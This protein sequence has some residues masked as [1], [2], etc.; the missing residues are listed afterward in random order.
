MYKIN[1][2]DKAFS[3]P[4]RPK[5]PTPTFG[6]AFNMGTSPTI[7]ET[8][9]NPLSFPEINES[10]NSQFVEEGNKYDTL[11]RDGPEF[12]KVSKKR[13]LAAI[14]A[15]GLAG[16]ANPELGMQVGEMIGGAPKR[17][18]EE[19]Y[20]RKLKN[21]ELLAKNEKSKLAD[22]LNLEGI[23]E[24]TRRFNIEDGRKSAEEKRRDA[25]L[26]NTTRATDASVA[27][28][29]V[30]TEAGKQDI[31]LRKWG[32]YT[33]P[34]DGNQYRYRLDNPDD[35]Q[36]I[37]KVAITPGE[38]LD[39]FKRRANHDAAN[40]LRNSLAVVNRQGELDKESDLRDF[41]KATTVADTAANS[42]IT[43]AR[44]KALNRSKELKVSEQELAKQAAVFEAI[45][46]AK[47]APGD[48]VEYDMATGAMTV[49]QPSWYS[50]D[51]DEATK[52]LKETVFNIL[53]GKAGGT[54][55]SAASASAIDSSNPPAGAPTG[56]GW[57][58]LDANKTRWGRKK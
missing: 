37:G 20:G 8:Q 24:E 57:G 41:T 47:M 53:S 54:N 12:E 40:N 45:A 22:A 35:K 21:Q 39:D 13:R 18:A 2:F 46:A 23:K 36:L 43:V 26:N 31:E 49:K 10:L 51:E 52:A 50:G 6:G 55:T 27:A 32:T 38:S 16:A 42:R 33:N 1:T 5:K 30:N 11:L 14:L 17:Q 3:T 19:A 48:V 29:N 44:E 15:G 58:W 56:D 34:A 28:S 4:I 9:A 7:K 25:E